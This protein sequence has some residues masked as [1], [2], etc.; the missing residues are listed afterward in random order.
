MNEDKMKIQL[1]KI[2]NCTPEE[3]TIKDA[4]HN[5]NG[6]Y[7]VVNFKRNDSDFFSM[8]TRTGIPQNK[9]TYVDRSC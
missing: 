6:E 4:R 1:A 8:L 2:M 7:G 5:V 3:I 9:R